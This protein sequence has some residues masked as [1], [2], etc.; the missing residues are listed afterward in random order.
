MRPRDRRRHVSVRQLP[1]LLR[2][3]LITLCLSTPVSYIPWWRLC[4]LLLTSALTHVNICYVKP[5][6]PL[7]PTPL[8][9]RLPLLWRLPRPGRHLH[10]NVAAGLPVR[11]R[12][13]R[14][15]AGRCPR[16]ARPPNAQRLGP[17]RDI[18][19]CRPA[20]PARHV[21]WSTMSAGITTSV[22]L[23]IARGYRPA[24]LQVRRSPPDTAC[25]ARGCVT[26]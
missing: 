14:R 16:A 23:R 22:L 20:P 26:L 2:G 15:R 9:Y 11:G 17:S 3:S 19:R 7:L 24:A 1:E 6:I 5:S 13:R 8:P 12:H 18:A 21:R 4:P 10:V 25:W